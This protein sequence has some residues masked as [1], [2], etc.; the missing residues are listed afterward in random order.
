MSTVF[1]I[2][3]STK[4]LLMF[5]KVTKLKSEKLTNNQIAKKLGIHRSTVSRYINMS[6]ETFLQSQTYKRRYPSKL[7]QYESN[8]HQQLIDC[9]DLSA[10][11]IHDRLKER[12][13]DF[14]N[15]SEK[16]VYNFVQ[17]VRHKHGIDKNAPA[18]Q[19]TKCEETPYGQYAQVD[20]G[21]RS[22]K[23]TSGI[24][25]KVYFFV[26]VLS[27]SRAK[28]TYLSSTPFNSELAIYAHELAFSY[29]QGVP[30]VILYDQDRVFIVK[31]NFGNY[32][33]TQK[34]EAYVT[35]S[36]FKAEFCRK[37][38]PES[39]GKCE[40][41]VKYIKSNFLKGRVFRDVETLNR[42][43]IA[44]LERTG[45]GK[46]HA[47]TRKV[48]SEV[49]KI[50]KSYLNPYQGIPRKPSIQMQEYVV[51]QDNTIHYKGNFYSVP[52]GTYVNAKSFCFVELK[53]GVIYLYN[54]DSG[55]QIAQYQQS[56]KKG[57]TIIKPGHY[58]EREYKYP[59][60]EQKILDH[61]G[62]QEHVL[63]YLKALRAHSPR[64]YCDAL[65]HIISKMG[66]INEEILSEAMMEMIS[67]SNYNVSMLIESALTQH[68]QKLMKQQ[69]ASR[70]SSY[71]FDIP[72][73]D[74]LEKSDIN[75]YQELMAQL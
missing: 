30:Q 72:H 32:H 47:G 6:E 17:K 4:R 75:Y 67:Y 11:Q 66:Q 74:E 51:R 7:D 42:E 5:H 57:E 16:T 68:R 37:E 55:K 38:D 63:P 59:D 70:M 40:N 14:P 19:Y 36:S 28:F 50:E 46:M 60:L 27:R 41:A 18:R 10:S 52:Q 39:K 8:I 44:W 2:S 12:F 23:D 58:K 25:R 33:L 35:Q 65:R 49:L 54:K 45:N 21:E 24:Y 15:T 53:D 43:A 73:G 29:F 9:G 61:L 71:R 13:P 1:T 64:H 48:P 26:M 22:I 69:S 3:S 31:E 34:F 56:E 62:P 20:F